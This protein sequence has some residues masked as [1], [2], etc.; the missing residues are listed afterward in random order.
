MKFYIDTYPEIFE[1]YN[2]ELNG[3]DYTDISDDE[4]HDDFWWNCTNEDCRATYK[5]TIQRRIASRDAFTKGCPYCAGKRVLREKS[6]RS[7]T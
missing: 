6:F 2:K 5:V 4:I 3:K 7:I 1:D